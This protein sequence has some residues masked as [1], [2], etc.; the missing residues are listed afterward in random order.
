MTAISENPLHAFAAWTAEAEADWSAAALERAQNAF[1]DTIAVMIPGAREDVTQKVHSVATTWGA[2][3]CTLVGFSER[4]SPP[5]AALV[6]GT[7]AHA[8]DFDDDFDPAKAHPSASIV[9]ALLALADERGATTAR[10]L[11]AYIVG[12]QIT[13]KVGQGVNPFHRS[14]GWHATSTVGTL[15]CAAACARLLGLDK[16]RT[17]HAIS[18]STSFAGGFMSQFG[19]MTKPLHA[20][21]A[22]SGAVQAALLAE[23]GITAGENTLHGDKGMGTLMVGPD[24]EELRALMANKDEFG[25]KVT[26]DAANVG[27]PLHIEKYGVKTKRFPNCGSIHRALDGLLDLQAE[28]GFAASDVRDILV[29]APAVLLRNLMYENPTTPMEARFSLEYS[30]AVGLFTGNATLEDYEEEALGR[31]GVRA[32]MLLIRKEYIDELPSDFPTEVHITLKDGRRFHN[33]VAMAKGTI[34]APLSDEQLWDKFE[35]CT[36]RFLDHE[37]QEALR[38]I[39]SNMKSNQ[40]ARTLTALL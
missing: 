32:L 6:N 38:Q 9:P 5:M 23:A 37:Q 8:L 19:T 18:L 30:L 4:L 39:L 29:R 34:A 25:Q 12:L 2:G 27:S 40:D 20:G 33:S 16:E 35:N 1:I 31:E 26:F 14:R 13:G 11:D 3:N 10:L 21:L 28:H 24:V 7:A 22:A 17:A 36:G 15:G